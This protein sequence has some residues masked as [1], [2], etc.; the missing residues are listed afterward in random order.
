MPSII[1]ATALG[2]LLSL[3]IE[4]AQ[5]YISTRVPSLTDLTLNAVGTL[6]GVTAGLAWGGLSR[7]MHLPGRAERPLRDPGAMLLLGLWLAWR[8]APFVPQFD[9]VKLKL[10]LRPLFSAAIRPGHGL[11]LPD[12]LAGGE[13]GRGRRRQQAAAPGSA[14]ARHC[15]R[16]GRPAA[17]REPD[18]PARRVARVVVAAADAARHAS[19][20]AAA[21][22]H[23]T[24]VRGDRRPDHRWARAVRLHAADGPLR[25]VA[26]PRLVRDRPAR[27]DP[28]DRLERSC[29][30]NCSCTARC[31]GSSRSGARRSASP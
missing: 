5:V 18:V 1:A 24:G 12:V 22:A 29:S 17:G 14:A 31:S 25:A 15:D 13:P 27:G 28:A 26:V 7:L 23:G 3:S 4:I 21:A 20:A 10:A 8:F 16:A 2:T 19:A 11:Q 6:L 9:L 30:A